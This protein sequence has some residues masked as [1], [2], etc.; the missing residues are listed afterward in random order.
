MVERKSFQVRRESEMRSTSTDKE[1][2][3]HFDK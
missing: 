3:E 2:L 1:N